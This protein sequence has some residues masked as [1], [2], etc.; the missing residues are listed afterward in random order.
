[1]KFK[2]KIKSIHPMYYISFFLPLVI[3][4]AIFAVRGIYPF[5]DN[6]YLRSDMY[7]QYCPF[8]SEL[9]DKIRNGGSLFYS[10]EIGLGS[11]FT[12]LY[13]YYLSSPLNWFIGFFPH[14]YI[15]ELM[16][17]IILIKL[18]LASTTF[19]YYI[20]K[21]F[22][23]RNITV[24]IF[25]MFYALS[26]FTAA[27]SWNLMWFDCMLLL[28]LVLLG[29]ERLINEDKGILYTITLGLTILSNYYIAIM[30]CISIVFYFVV[31]LVTMPVPKRKSV[32]LQ[33]IGY[34]TLF[35]LLAGALSAAI[36]L[37]ELYAL[38]LTASSDI[39]FPK[40]LT[41][42]FSV[43]TVLNRQLANTEVCIGL[44]H[45]PNI[46]CGVA[47]F[48]LYPLYIFNKKI[49]LREKI[50]KSILLFVF[51]FAF[52][53][54]IP[55]FIWHGFH[56]PNSLPARQSFIYIFILLTMCFDAYK[57]M[58]DYSISQ[59]T[60]AFGLFLIYLLWLDHSGGD[61]DPD[62]TILFINAVFMLLYVI[63]AFLYKKDKLKIHF[64]VFLLFCVSCIECTMNMEETGYSTTGRSAYFKDYESVQTLTDELSESDDSFYRIAKAFGYR[65]KNDA[66]WHNF[67]SASVFSS[68]AYAGITD[69]FGQL[70]LEHSMNAYADH[71]ATPLVYSMFDIKYILSNKEL[72]DDYT[73]ELVDVNDGEYLYH[74]KYTLPLGYM[75]KS[76]I[77]DEWN[78]KTSNPFSVQNDFVLD[79]TGI[80]SLFTA[81]DFIDN[82]KNGINID[83]END[84]YVY[85][86]IANKSVKTAKVTI[87]DDSENFAGINHGRIIDLGWQT[88]GTQIRIADKDGE[89]ALNAMV[90]TM[91]ANKFIDA[92]NLLNSQ[93]LNVTS[94]TDTT[95]T[96]TINVNEAGI[97]MLSIPYDPSWTLKVNGVKTQMTEVAEA[98]IGVELE[99]G[100]YTIELSFTPRGFKL[101]ILISTFALLILFLVYCFYRKE[102][103][104]GFLP[105]TK[106]KNIPVDVSDITEDTLSDKDISD[107]ND[108]P[109]SKDISGDSMSDNTTGVFS[110]AMPNDT[111]KNAI[112]NAIADIPAKDIKDDT[113]NSKAVKDSHNTDK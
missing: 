28:P 51:I 82:D 62:Y 112:D 54:N 100:E 33:K 89:E 73:L 38:G 35:S 45:L 53:F 109:D 3:M 74:A 69:L 93:G 50:A 106:A 52:S 5:G 34:F 94:Y 11:N 40:T 66:A 21:R 16:N 48:L 25:G 99:P 95:I 71:G 107:D 37:P 97:L 87:D 44:E 12:A 4:I 55:N 67:N 110:K 46:Y 41:Q 61:N 102:A 18:S 22:N 26:G 9:W 65:S 92:F 63:I 32:Y 42:Y 78:Y 104:K 108:I 79:N 1:M 80:P 72:H 20:A 24:S 98:L 77:N 70:G 85:I 43:I 60:K 49:S 113:N 31:L 56:Y 39:S 17:I 90:Y 15:I 111:K 23:V 47:V 84:G 91:D 13:G 19:T 36:L 86:Y 83:V 81:L 2:E 88:A 103:G 30:V 101:G 29:L 75:V 14:N 105:F 7:H 96:G 10:W 58:K 27:F 76:D 8:F 64:I 68:T 57:D 59:I 6:V